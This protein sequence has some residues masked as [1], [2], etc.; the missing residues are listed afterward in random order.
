MVWFWRSLEFWGPGGWSLV[1]KG[2]SLK[3]KTIL[4][5]SPLLVPNPPW[6]IRHTKDTAATHLLPEWPEFL[7]N[8]EVEDEPLVS[9]VVSARYSHPINRTVTRTLYYISWHLIRS[10]LGK[11]GLSLDY[12]LQGC[13]SSQ[14]G[15]HD[16]RSRPSRSE[17]RESTASEA[18]PWEPTSS[19][20][21]PILRG[22]ADFPDRAVSSGVFK[23]WAC[24][25]L[26][27]SKP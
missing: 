19:N 14:W 25:R 22:S 20:K 5:P 13:I 3:I 12:R 16:V 9:S 1:T 6:C 18:W 27:T 24:G 26:F 8:H 4:A 23:Q 7:W 2:T 21:V 10:S 11:E 15:K 17:S